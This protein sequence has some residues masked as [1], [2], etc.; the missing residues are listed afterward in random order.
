MS[1]HLIVKMET[2]FSENFM[3]A[4]SVI[5]NEKWTG[6]TNFDNDTKSQKTAVG[7]TWLGVVNA[8]I[9]SKAGFGLTCTV[10]SLFSETSH[11]IG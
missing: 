7:P 5:R 9:L 6:C 3:I 8:W 1:G 4:E 2:G 11:F 10:L